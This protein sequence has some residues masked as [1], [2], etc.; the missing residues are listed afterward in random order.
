[1]KK[2]IE[3]EEK[4]KTEWHIAV[5]CTINKICTGENTPRDISEEPQE[6]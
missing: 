2:Y 5:N 1:M 3:N 4:D 6:P